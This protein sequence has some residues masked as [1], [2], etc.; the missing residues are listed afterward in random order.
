MGEARRRLD[1]GEH[2]ALNYVRAQTENVP[3]RTGTFDVVSAGQSSL[4]FER[5]TVTREVRRV[6]RPG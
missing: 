3:A 4:W 1:R 2:R 6:L 5:A